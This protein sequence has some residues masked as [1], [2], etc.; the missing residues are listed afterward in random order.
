VFVFGDFK[1]K[2]TRDKLKQIIKEELEEILGQESEVKDINQFS[3]VLYPKNADPKNLENQYAARESATDPNKFEI[4]DAKSFTFKHV[5]EKSDA[6]VLPGK[7]NL[8]WRISEKA[9]IT[10]PIQVLN[11]MK[12]NDIITAAE[13][14]SMFYAKYKKDGKKYVCYIRVNGTAELY[15]PD[16]F[17]KG[18][19]TSPGVKMTPDSLIDKEE[20]KKLTK[21]KKVQ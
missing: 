1:M 17:M 12:D 11:I 5:I 16:R 15:E 2:L 21:I 18:Y 10:D 13:N 6:K 9:D 4:F 7:T 3:F 14:N 20:A 19:E 8:A